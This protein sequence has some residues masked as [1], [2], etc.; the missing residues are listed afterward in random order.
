MTIKEKAKQLID[1]Y[2]GVTDCNFGYRQQLICAIKCANEVIDQWEYIDT[3]L[4]DGM[5]E[6]NPN[7]T[8]W[9]GV[10]EELINLRIE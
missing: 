9:L 4:G 2:Y 7:L 1:N 3:Y 8:Y 10:R 5:G 6:L